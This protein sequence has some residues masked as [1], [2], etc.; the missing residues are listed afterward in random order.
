MTYAARVSDEDAWM[1]S[2]VET[3]GSYLG[4]TLEEDEGVTRAAGAKEEAAT[5]PKAEKL[6]RSGT[7]QGFDDFVPDGGD[8]ED[9]VA[10]PADQDRRVSIDDGAKSKDGSFLQRQKTGGEA[11]RAAAVDADEDCAEVTFEGGAKSRDGA[12]L[13]RQQTGG[14]A[15]ARRGAVEDEE[16]EDE[17][18]EE[19]EEPQRPPR[20]TDLQHAAP[21]PVG[22]ARAPPRWTDLQHET[23]APVGGARRTS[24]PDAAAQAQF[25]VEKCGS[26]I[27]DFGDDHLPRGPKAWFQAIAN[28][29]LGPSLEDLQAVLWDALDS[30]HRMDGG[31]GEV[32]AVEKVVT[33]VAASSPEGAPEVDLFGPAAPPGLQTPEATSPVGNPNEAAVTPPPGTSTGLA[34]PQYQSYEPGQGAPLP[35]PEHQAFARLR[36]ALGSSRRVAPKAPAELRDPETPSGDCT[37]LVRADKDDTGAPSVAYYVMS[38]WLRTMSVIWDAA[39]GQYGSYL[40]LDCHAA[41][42]ELVLTWMYPLLPPLEDEMGMPRLMTIAEATALLSWEHLDEADDLC[43]RHLLLM[44]PSAEVMAIALKHD[45]A[46]VVERCAAGIGANGDL[47]AALKYLEAPVGEGEAEER[48]E[49]ARRQLLDAYFDRGSRLRAAT[50]KMKL[51]SG[52][53]EDASR[54]HR[55]YRVCPETAELAPSAREQWLLPSGIVPGPASV[56]TLRPDSGFTTPA[57]SRSTPG[58]RQSTPVTWGRSP[59][60]SQQSSPVT[61]GAAPLRASKTA[62]FAVGPPGRA[63]KTAFAAAFVT[64]FVEQDDVKD[65]AARAL[66]L[67]GRVRKVSKPTSPPTSEQYGGRPYPKWRLPK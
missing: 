9:E 1:P 18:P 45:M 36:A 8:E 27:A 52:V 21:E 28:S 17:E 22:G 53:R 35:F 39:L 51:S 16:V 42:F 50:E 60:W 33:A 65:A 13:Q 57:S 64:D 55:R 20:W 58:T 49:C 46:P 38:T 3:R 19:P 34:P 10:Q 63:S 2:R 25:F 62:S 6:V 30:G 4:R 32:E 66:E 54:K 59:T 56:R 67:T 44:K 29:P 41:D 11:L 5:E 37:V 14:A 26:V 43:Q 23:P 31:A 40:A 61:W 15:L 7:F 24:G 12:F 48:W 47:E